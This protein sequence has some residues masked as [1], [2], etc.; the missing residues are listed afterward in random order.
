MIENPLRQQICAA[1]ESKRNTLVDLVVLQLW[2]N[3]FWEDRYGER[4]K[5]YFYDD[6]QHHVQAL[7]TA[8]QL[9]LPDALP[10]HYAW[11]REVLVHRGMCTRHLYQTLRVFDAQLEA[12]LPEYWSVIR[13]YAE[14]TYAGLAYTDPLCLALA[15]VEEPLIARVMQR[16][17]TEKPAWAQRLG[18]G[19][20]TLCRQDNLYHLSYLQDALAFQDPRIFTDYLTWISAFLEARRLTPQ[21][22]HLA[23][24]Y[25]A[26]E[27]EAALPAVTAAPAVQLLR[28]AITA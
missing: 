6:A 25:L 16:I 7:I 27:I 5:R 24:G 2:A 4:G 21:M 13:P 14:T 3:P 9:D 18:P 22:L 28:S 8:I 26:E 10:Q 23:M 19:G 11:L 17:L 20:K 15:Q 12:V 1:L